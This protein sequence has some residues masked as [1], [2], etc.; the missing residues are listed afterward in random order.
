MSI[1][2]ERDLRQQL[3]RILDAIMPPD[4]PVKA[5]ARKGKLIQAGRSLGVVAGLAVVAGIG[6]GGAE[7]RD[8]GGRR[9]GDHRQSGAGR[10][11]HRAAV[12]SAGREGATRHRTRGGRLCLA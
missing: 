10:R 5:A 2:D 4:A 3:D 9:P 11:A 8:R 7:L 6:D 1:V 12:G